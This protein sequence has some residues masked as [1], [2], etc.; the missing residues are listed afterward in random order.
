[1]SKN[2][3][4]DIS[5]SKA[6]RLQRQKELA[7][8]KR[9]KALS[10]VVAILVVVAIV[11]LL[12][13]LIGWNVYKVVGTTTSSQ[14]F[15]KYIDDNGFIKDVDVNSAVT[16]ADYQNHVVPM[17]EVAATEEE[18]QSDIDATLESNQILSGDATKAVAD[19]DKVNIDY[20]GTID[21]VE[22]E[23]GNSNGEGSDLTIGSGQFIDNFEEQ[24]IGH[25]PGEEMTV[26]VTFPEDYQNADLAGK[27]A[28]FAVTI[29]GI[30]VTP[31]LTD[32]FV[33]ENLSEYATTADEYR[34]YV[35]D[36]FYKE[37]LTDY[38]ETYIKDNSTVNSYPSKY[39]KNLKETLKY[40]DEMNVEYYNQMYQQ[41]TGSA[42]YDT[43][44]DMAGQ[45]WFDYEKSLK[46]RAQDAAKE[47]MV[48]QSI[49]QK[50]GL[51]IDVNA[52]LAELDN[53]YGEGYSESVTTQMGQ[54]Y[55]IQQH[56]KEVVTDYLLET[57][58][59]Q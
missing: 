50:A 9:N 56:I 22:F 32:D 39:V 10:S 25:N 24:L 18:V 37:H 21:G 29:N 59:V 34:A 44:Y 40:Q 1:M 5:K 38:I 2:Q 43:V 55:F 11:G 17:S 58:T 54:G 51:T 30:Y 16:V 49:F 15:S 47:A 13:G 6:K 20:V 35:E 23:G 12:A 4:E 7:S 41:Y 3:T 14:E 27:A 26:N 45:S 52:Y 36:K 46:E 42:M 57:V 28:A 19:G 53:Q 31:E 48:Y 33:A 8:Q